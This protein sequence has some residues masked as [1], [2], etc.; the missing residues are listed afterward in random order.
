MWN[1]KT[2]VLHFEQICSL[3]QKKIMTVPSFLQTAVIVLGALLAISMK[4]L[5]S[6]RPGTGATEPE[7]A[8]MLEKVL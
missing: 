3:N 6:D 5:E 1:L 7:N 2:Y 8:E 4:D